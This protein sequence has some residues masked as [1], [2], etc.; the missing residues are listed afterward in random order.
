MSLLEPLSELGDLSPETIRKIQ[1]AVK[2][3]TR[4]KLPVKSEDDLAEAVGLALMLCSRL[5][6]S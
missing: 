4:L 3:G 5:A 6:G 1:Q 2:R